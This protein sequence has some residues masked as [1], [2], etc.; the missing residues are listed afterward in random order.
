MKQKAEST[1]VQASLRRK[2]E[3]K[4]SKEASNSW[5]L[6]LPAGRLELLANS[7]NQLRI[8]GKKLN[9]NYVSMSYT[10]PVME[11]NRV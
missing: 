11:N 9:K 4:A 10:F 1:T 5:G 7:D 3:R 2:K 6:N 8:D